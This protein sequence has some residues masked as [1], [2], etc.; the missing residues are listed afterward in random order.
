VEK[1]VMEELEKHTWKTSRNVRR[2]PTA[3]VTS[4]G[5][6]PWLLAP[7]PLGPRWGATPPHPTPT[8]S[9]V[10]ASICG[11]WLTWFSKAG[12]SKTRLLGFSN[13]MRV[14]SSFQNHMGELHKHRKGAQ[15]LG[16]FKK[17]T[18]TII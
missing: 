15:L 16:S 11:A 9:R 7:P 5:E 12:E 4:Q 17:I 3:K 8:I 1:D 13:K 18:N 2:L 10:N 6:G 14:L